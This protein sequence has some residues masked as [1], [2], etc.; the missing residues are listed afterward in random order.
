[1]YVQ[2]GV[3]L[4]FTKLRER[5]ENFFDELDDVLDKRADFHLRLD[6]PDYGDLFRRELRRSFQRKLKEKR[7]G[8]LKRMV[9]ACIW[10]T[11]A[12]LALI[13]WGIIFQH[14]ATIIIG[15]AGIVAC[16]WNYASGVRTLCGPLAEA[17]LEASRA[18]N[19]IIS[20]TPQPEPSPA[21]EQPAATQAAQPSGSAP[22][23]QELLAMAA[24]QAHR[25]SQS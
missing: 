2:K 4:M 12:L 21:P 18:I 17:D 15:L 7:L 14:G 9:R 5:I 20:G 1:M 25:R 10:G 23:N 16:I 11:V 6:D 13:L 3:I 24:H 22:T 19:S 8:G